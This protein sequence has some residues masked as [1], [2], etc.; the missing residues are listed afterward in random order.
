[1][2]AESVSPNLGFGGFICTCNALADAPKAMSVVVKILVKKVVA[3]HLTIH[4]GKAK[5]WDLFVKLIVST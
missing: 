1:M 4:S 3:L 2:I 5:L